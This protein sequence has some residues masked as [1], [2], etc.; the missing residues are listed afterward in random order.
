MPLTEE[1]QKRLTEA[2]KAR[3]ARVVDTLRMVRS[4]IME[5][6]NAK[7]FSGEMTDAR[8]VDTI[9]AYVKQLKKALPD[10]ERAGDVGRDMAD[11]LRFEIDYLSGFLPKLL[12]EAA[13]RVIVRDTLASLG[14]TDAK[15][16]G[17]VM[18]AIMK[19]YPGQVEPALVRRLIDEVLQTGATGAGG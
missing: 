7:D 15:R 6:R 16:A 2:M 12:D 1:I 19:A 5:V 8:V 18:G 4:K 13:T 14:V 3:D 17:Q 9:S 10:Y 11:K